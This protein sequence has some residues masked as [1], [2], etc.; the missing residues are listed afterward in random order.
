[1]SK[2]ITD[3]TAATTPLAGTEMVEIVQGGVSKKVAASYL[4]AGGVVVRER[5]SAARTYYVR[6]DG[7]DS[8]DGLT[9]T[10]GGAFLTL[11]KA[12]NV[13]LTLDTYGYAVTIKAAD[14][15]YTAGVSIDKPL[16]GGGQLI[17]EGNTTTPSNAVISLSSGSCFGIS[18]YAIATVRGF[19]LVNSGGYGILCSVGGRVFASSMEYGACSA[20]HNRAFGVGAAVEVTGAITVSGN[21]GIFIGGDGGGQAQ[22]SSATVT[23]S[24]TITFSTAFAWATR[25]G[26]VRVFTITWAGSHASVVG[27]KYDY[28]LNATGEHNG[29]TLVGGTAGTTATGAEV[30]A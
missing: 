23:F 8:N 1:M 3:L 16:V 21:A 22:L 28:T 12:Y 13:A 30:S 11:Q 24:G 7:S 14:G 9:N 5:L 20:H 10:S 19:K 2:K 17:V 25:G 26:G 18:N 27:K 6:T 4:G 15:T 29:V